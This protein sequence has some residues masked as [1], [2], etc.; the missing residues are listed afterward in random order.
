MIIHYVKNVTDYD[1]LTL[2]SALKKY[3]ETIVNNRAIGC[4]R[5]MHHEVQ[6]SDA[7]HVIEEAVLLY[8]NLNLRI[9]I[10]STPQGDN[11]KCFW[12]NDFI[13][14]GLVGLGTVVNKIKHLDIITQISA[15]AKY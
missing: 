14:F 7:S 8:P 13:F 4:L 12:E 11:L 1:H 6:L 2:E 15:Y 10:L 3:Q 9:R 5:A